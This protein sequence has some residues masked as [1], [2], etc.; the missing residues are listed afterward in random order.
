[1][2]RS[3]N[4]HDSILC[5]QP[6]CS[7]GHRKPLDGEMRAPKGGKQG[8]ELRNITRK[9][10]VRAPIEDTIEILHS[11]GREALQQCCSAENRGSRL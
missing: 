4:R 2:D 8:F 10:Q 11:A 3:R 1:M 6:F 5:D 7:S 9:K